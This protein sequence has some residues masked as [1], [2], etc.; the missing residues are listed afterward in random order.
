MS[1]PLPAPSPS[2][3][4]KEICEGNISLAHFG[5][6]LND[7][8][9]WYWTLWKDACLF[10][11][12][13]P[14]SDMAMGTSHGSLQ[15]ILQWERRLHWSSYLEKTQLGSFPTF[16]WSSLFPTQTL[17]CIRLTHSS[18]LPASCP[19][20]GKTSAFWPS[21]QGPALSQGPSQA[22]PPL[23]SPPWW[24]G[25]PFSDSWATSCIDLVM[26]L[27]LCVYFVSPDYLVAKT[28]YLNK[29]INGGW[30]HAYPAQNST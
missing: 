3:G 7:L 6:V 11:N 22:S 21:G 12:L 26:F 17:C 2:K 5:R 9:K 24:H 1:L 18:P 20:P 4:F 13:L 23:G 8:C 19:L 28:Q 27:L 16:T 14:V 30:R 25:M 15:R 10:A 29:G